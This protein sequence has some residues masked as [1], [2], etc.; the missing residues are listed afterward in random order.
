MK[1]YIYFNYLWV[2]KKAVIIR[3]QH[4][5]YITLLSQKKKKNNMHYY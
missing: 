2:G 3:H 5:V 1:N 4:M